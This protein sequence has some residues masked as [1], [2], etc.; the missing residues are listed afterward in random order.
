MDTITYFKERFEK[1][2]EGTIDSRLR[3]LRDEAFT[4]FEQTGIP[5]VKHEE[6]KYTRINDFFNKDY[7]FTTDLKEQEFKAADLQPFLLP[8][9]E[10]ANSIVFING[11]YHPEH[12]VL[13]SEELEIISLEEAAHNQYA[14]VVEAHLG[15]SADYHKDGINALNT[16]F[17]QE[18]VFVHIQKG[19]T[20][21]HP[22]YIYNITDARNGNIFAQPRALVHIGAYAQVEM[23]ETFATIGADESFTNQV[24]E[25]AVEEGAVLNLYKIQNDAS[26]STI[27]STTHVHQVGK[28]VANVVTISLNGGLI[29]NNL[30]MVMSAPYCESNLSGLYLQNGHTHVDNHTVVDNREPNCLSYELYKGILD[31]ASTGVFNGKIFVRQIAQKTNAYQTNRNVLLSEN[32]SVNTKPQLEIFADDVKCSH[33][34][35]VGRLDEEALFY[36]KSRGISDATARSLLLRGFALDIL[37]KIH[38]ESVRE[39]V[40]LL[41]NKRLN[42]G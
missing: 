1:L 7:H 35:T 17:I 2:Q 14:A 29:R 18:G 6:W 16:A 33:G 21:N 23:L 9:H 31:D 28:S 38:S 40:D 39:Y 8:G 20:V 27:V 25:I 36:M 5:T 12:S 13:R 26:N 24:F 41:V 34:C 22:V 37:D 4:E 3:S 42:I 19:K 11:H 30:N 15:H 10:N 32:A